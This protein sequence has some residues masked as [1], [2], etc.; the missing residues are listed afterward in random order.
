MSGT[1]IKVAKQALALFLHSLPIGSKFNVFS[2]GSTFESVFEESVNYNQETMDKAKAAV[3]SLEANKGGTEIYALL[4]HIL[5]E[6]E[7]RNKLN[8]QVFLLTDGAVFD[9]ED[10]LNLVKENAKKFSF[11]TF[12]IGDN[13]SLEFI[14]GFTKAAKGSSY[15]VDSKAN[16]LETKVINALRKVFEPKVNILSVNAA[17]D[18]ELVH[19]YPSLSN[20][21]TEINHGEYLT[22]YMI[23]EY[24]E[25]HKISGCLSIKIQEGKSSS[26]VN[27]VFNLEKDVKEIPGDS[28]FKMFCKDYVEDLKFDPKQ[29]K[30]VTRLC[31]KYQI[32][33]KYTAFVSDLNVKN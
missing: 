15:L 14:T 22:Y 7:D 32:S 18:G 17:C 3:K 30:F 16:G 1:R 29:D 2:F 31:L 21:V 23:H 20:K 11:N 10:C 26:K 8:K 12:G 19:E 6:L 33:S 27:K 13:V 4:Y 28:I 5:M 25:E 24:K 9:P